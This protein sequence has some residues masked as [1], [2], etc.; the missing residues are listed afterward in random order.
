MRRGRVALGI[1]AFATLLTLS[2][3]A[4]YVNSV[5]GVC[6]TAATATPSCLVPGPN[7]G[8]PVT[9]G[10][11]TPLGYQQLSTI[12]SATAL[13]IPAG[14]TVAYVTAE[15]GTVRYRDDGTNPTT[16]VG[17]PLTQGFTLIYVATP[18]TAVKFIDTST[19]AVLSVNYYK[20]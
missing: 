2:P 7:G 6:D 15:S 3:V 8:F 20:P 10:K 5:V 16:T 14:A 19:G 9:P 12:S 11:L 1:V 18:L 17:T 4:A 13:T